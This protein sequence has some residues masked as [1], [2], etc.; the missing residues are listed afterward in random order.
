MLL[1]KMKEG[2]RVVGGTYLP[3][4]TR[5]VHVVDPGTVRIDSG[6]VR[7]KGSFR[8]NQR[9][10]SAR[11][12]SVILCHERELDVKLVGLVARERSVDYAMLELH[13]SDG[14]RSEKCRYGIIRFSPFGSVQTHRCRSSLVSENCEDP[15]VSC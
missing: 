13:V 9:S 12:L 1:V 8:Y 3:P 5:L 4:S 6:A 2:K 15:T 11:T 7:H 14:Y 10:W